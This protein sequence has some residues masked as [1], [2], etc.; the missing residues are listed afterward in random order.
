MIADIS[1]TVH[2]EFGLYTPYPVNITPSCTPYT[3][4]SGFGNVVNFDTSMFTAREESL[5]FNNDFVAT[6]SSYMEMYDIYNEARER[7]APIFVSCDAL[8]HTY[9]I[10]YDRI[11]QTIEMEKLVSDISNFTDTLY[12]LIKEEWDSVSAPTVK[13][14]LFLDVAYL[15][16]AKCLLD[17]TFSPLSEVDSVVHAE[18]A[19]IHA[20]V[21]FSSSPIFDSLEDYSQYVPR[22]HYTKNDTLKRY[23]RAMMWYGR[24]TFVIDALHTRMALLVVHGLHNIEVNGEQGID[25]WERIYVPTMFFVGKSDDIHLPQYAEIMTE[26]Y[27]SDFASL[28]PDSFAD[29]QLLGEFMAEADLLPDPAIPTLTAKGFRFMGQRFVPDSWIFSQLTYDRIPA[30]RYHPKGLDVMSVLGSDHAYEILDQVY[31]E[32]DYAGYADKMDSLKVSFDA[33]PDATWAQNLYWN[34]LYCLM[35]FAFAKGT[36]FPSF[37]CNT[38]WIRKELCCALGSWSELRH[39]TILY[40]KQSCSVGVHPDSRIIHGYVEPN[41]WLFARLAAL[42]RYMRDGLDDLGLLQFPDCYF[43]ERLIG[44]ERLLLVLKTIAEK[45]LTGQTVSSAEDKAIV[46]IGPEIV[47]LVMFD[48]DSDDYTCPWFP[49]DG[50]ESDDQMPIIADVHT[51]PGSCLEEGTGYPFNLYVVVP[52]NGELTVTWGAGFSYYEFLQPISNRLTDEAWQ[53]MLQTNPP[54]PPVWMASFVDTQQLGAIL[55]PHHFY[56]YEQWKTQ[57]FG[58]EERK[59]SMHRVNESGLRVN[60]NPTGDRS[61]IT[62]SVYAAEEQES[63][64]HL[65]VHDATGRLVSVLVHTS[66]RPGTYRIRWDAINRAGAS[67][68]QGIYFVSLQLPGVRK[69]QKTILLR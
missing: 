5:L 69:V 10:L 36:G 65:T 62:Y 13:E 48:G 59:T 58:V 68:P 44:L 23:F 16:V 35:P 52:L 39:D 31:H 29:N 6:P 63:R 27:G 50:F 53:Q 7:K 47:K 19:L 42:T 4:D 37:M 21:G 45:E 43:E 46:G 24:M 3:I 25:I 28:P 64:V 8:L 1:D 56:P 54:E 33:L 32:T 57:D 12:S 34:W 49:G 41:P 60:S 38:A 26:V 17:P 30:D 51:G 67:L 14:A 61:Y 9:H 40:A 66:Q 18:L 22:G 20:H 2:T 11:L 55:S 15:S